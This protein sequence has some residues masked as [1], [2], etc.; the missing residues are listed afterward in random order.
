[1]GET[2]SAV[3]RNWNDSDLYTQL[4][5]VIWVEEPQTFNL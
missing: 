4:I 3:R 2:K 5:E 1:M